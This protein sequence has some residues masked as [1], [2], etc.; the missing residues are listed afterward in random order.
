MVPPPS[1]ANSGQQTLEFVRRHQTSIL[2]GAAVVTFFWSFWVTWVAP[3]G[4]RSAS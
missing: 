3:L 1:P 2:I 4:R